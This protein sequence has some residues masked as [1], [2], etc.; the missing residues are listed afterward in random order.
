MTIVD[1]EPRTARGRFRE[2][3]ILTADT[4]AYDASGTL[5]A[6]GADSAVVVE[7]G[8]PIGVVTTAGLRRDRIAVPPATPVGDLLQWECVRIDRGAD[9]LATLR[10]YRAAAWA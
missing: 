2:S 9:A 10:T 3:L 1:N 8:E 5:A 7:S 4:P 6:A